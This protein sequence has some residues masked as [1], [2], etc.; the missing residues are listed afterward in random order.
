M[1]FDVTLVLLNA[2]TFMHILPSS[3]IVV[4]RVASTAQTEHCVSY[5]T[6]ADIVATCAFEVAIMEFHN[7]NYG[8]P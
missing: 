7:S 6:I 8:A 4:Y 2:A 3:Q 1:F 5:K